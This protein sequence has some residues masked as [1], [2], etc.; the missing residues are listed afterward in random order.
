MPSS[1]AIEQLV[2]D[3]RFNGPLTSANGGYAC[4]A[5]ARFVDGPAEVS[6]RHPPPLDTPLDARAGDEGGVSLWHGDTL[7][8]EGTP[9]G[10]PEVVPPVRPSVDEA[11]EAMR[12]AWDGRP[13]LLAHCY[14]C[15]L[16]RRD[17]LGVCFGRL[18]RLPELTCAT[19]TAGP[20]VP[21]KDGA[22]APEIAWAALDC[23]SYVP[24]LWD[25]G[26][27]LLARM[28]GELRAPV[29]AGEPVVCLGWGLFGEGRKQWTASALLSA[30]GKLLARAE[31][32]WIKLVTPAPTTPR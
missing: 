18:P 9:A 24:A 15:S 29:S 3:A 31:A 27:S 8:A 19:F 25:D 20:D 12:N 1:P 10:P 26:P 13:E 32:L 23:P 21:Q 17:G 30:D 5:V 22:L 6:L 4:G 7:V 14:V 16:H 2:I 28:H 11:L